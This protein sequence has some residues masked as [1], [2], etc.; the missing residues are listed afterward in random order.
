VRVGVLARS[1]RELQRSA[2]GWAI[3]V[4]GVS[5]LYAAF[6]PSIRDSAAA[7]QDYMSK[8]P[9]SVKSV[10]GAD[11]TTPAGYLRSELFSSLGVILFLI[12]AIGAGSRA[13]AGEEE[14]RTLDLVLSTPVRRRTLI[15]DKALAIVVTTFALAA[16]LFVVTLAAGP[17]FD[18]TVPVP[19]LVGACVMLALLAIAFGAIAL[20]IATWSG[21]RTL[22]NAVAGAIAVVSLV[23]NALA[24]QV[25]GLDPIRPLSP[26]RWYLE[27]DPLTSPLEQVNVLVLVGIA[28][29]AFVVALVAFDRRDL[30]A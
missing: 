1:F 24:A 13:I 6:Y 26:F 10:I 22:G 9:E 25:S 30:A 3:A 14:R 16:V 21:R 29:V 2:V 20:A 19:R 5:L 23:V 8:L 17:L 4:V 12:F 11:Y 28:V 7:L 18:L 27:P 15:G